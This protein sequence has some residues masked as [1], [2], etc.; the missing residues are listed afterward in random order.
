MAQ[1]LK[2][3]VVLV[4]DHPIVRQGFV[5][6]IN[7]EPDLVV[8]GEAWDTN[9]GLDIIHKTTPDIALIDLSL[10]DASGL[11]LIKSLKTLFPELPMLVV[12]LH[13]E[14]IYAERALRAGAKGFIMKAEATENIMEAIRAVLKG[15]IYLSDTMRELLLQKVTGTRKTSLVPVELLSDREFE[16]FLLIGD[17]YKTKA[18]AEKFNLSIKTV[19]TYKAYIKQKMKLKDATEL[20]QF[21]VEWNMKNIKKV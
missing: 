17:G 8:V 21:A 2:K 12:S 14:R 9:T 13:N 3:K 1:S 19:E 10:K 11:E 18:I 16:I 6:L 5:Q 20:I 7:Q 15:G 4:E